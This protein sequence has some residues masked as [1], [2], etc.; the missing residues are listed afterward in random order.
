MTMLH[1]DYCL[2]GVSHANL[3][4]T[5]QRIIHIDSQIRISELLVWDWE[6]KVNRTT[7][8]EGTSVAD[9]IDIIEF[10]FK[11]MK[12]LTF[13][14]CPRLVEVSTKMS[15]SVYPNDTGTI[16]EGQL[17][18]N[19]LLNQGISPEQIFMA[20]GK[21]LVF[22][23]R[24]L[25]VTFLNIA[26]EDDEFIVLSNSG[27]RLPS[28]LGVYNHRLLGKEVIDKLL[29]IKATAVDTHDEQ[30]ILVYTASIDELI[31]GAKPYREI[32]KELRSCLTKAGYN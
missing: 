12:Q 15:I 1:N 7:F 28:L 6:G 2:S 9:M 32:L 31:N 17:Y 23:A 20:L 29:S 25:D 19:H 14:L 21:L 13:L 16:I 4:I 10:D 3:E 5:A 30:F 22:L 8:E 27:V 18:L 26:D 24:C 11:A